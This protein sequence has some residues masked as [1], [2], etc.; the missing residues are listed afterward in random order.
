MSWT[1]WVACSKSVVGVVLVR[2]NMLIELLISWGFGPTF[3]HHNRTAVLF[4]PH[5]CV[6]WVTR[7]RLVDSRHAR[8]AASRSADRRRGGG[9]DDRLHRRRLEPTSRQRRRHLP[10]R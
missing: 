2:E 6:G 3:N 8:P 4:L 1:A 10:R 5:P 9:R 7:G